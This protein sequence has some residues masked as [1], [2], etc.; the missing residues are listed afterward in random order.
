MPCVSILSTIDIS[1]NIADLS[2]CNLIMKSA[3]VLIHLPCWFFS[4]S[5][6]S[7]NVELLRR[8]KGE[9]SDGEIIRKTGLHE[10]DLI[11]KLPYKLPCYKRS[12]CYTASLLHRIRSYRRASESYSRVIDRLT[13]MS[14][15]FRSTLNKNYVEWGVQHWINRDHDSDSVRGT[16]AIFF[17]SFKMMNQSSCKCV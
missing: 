12:E 9:D 10:C 7:Y 4:F 11:L 8:E 16:G 1:S 6:V 17:F 5:N 14:E 2:H 13:V 15:F 3:L